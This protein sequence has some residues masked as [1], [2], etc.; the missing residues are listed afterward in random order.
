MTTDQKPFIGFIG[1]GFVG[2]NTADE[3]E[4]RGYRVVRYALEEPYAQNK[5]T[6]A[7]CDVVFV[8]VPTPSVPADRGSAQGGLPMEF[9]DSIVRSVVPLTREGATVIIKSTV[10]PGTTQKLQE[11]FPDRYILFSPE[12]LSEAQAAYDVANP[13]M[14]I[15]GFPRDNEEFRQK[16]QEALSLMVQGPHTK[17]CS[18]GEAEFIKYAHNCSGYVQIVFVNLLYDLAQKLGCEWKVIEEA[19]RADPYIPNRYSRPV[20]KSGRGAGGHCF[21]KDFAAFRA[22]YEDM[23]PTDALGCAVLNA[24]EQKNVELL[25]ESGKD[26]DLIDGVYKRGK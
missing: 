5:D 22:F 25:R 21:L 24:L 26:T 18:A 16:A 17:M 11:E 3:M 10:L 23:L 7:K 6:I 14:T 15:V 20:H 12:F 1:Q 13:F 2:K 9:D 8:A 19:M 4:A